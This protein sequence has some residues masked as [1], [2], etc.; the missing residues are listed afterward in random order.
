MRAAVVASTAPAPEHLIENGHP[1]PKAWLSVIIDE[2]ARRK[3]VYRQAQNMALQGLPVDRSRLA[4]W[5]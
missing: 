5:G 2:H 3:P 4:D 1:E